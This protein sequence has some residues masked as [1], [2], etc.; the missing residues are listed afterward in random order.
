ML[1]W[2]R[3]FN[4]LCRFSLLA[5]RKHNWCLFDNQMCLLRRASLLL[6]SSRIPRHLHPLCLILCHFRKSRPLRDLLP[7]LS[8]DPALPF[9]VRRTFSILCSLLAVFSEVTRTIL[10]WTFLYYLPNKEVV[11]VP[12]AQTLLRESPFFGLP[13]LFEDFLLD[14]RAPLSALLP[15]THWNLF[16]LRL[17]DG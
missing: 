7:R 10:V 6:L 13:L 15:F 3:L 9:L 11:V 14:G 5:L 17:L 4:A 12:I 8:K 16:L 2:I 1:F